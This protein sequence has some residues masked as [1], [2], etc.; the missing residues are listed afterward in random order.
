MPE[1]LRIMRDEINFILKIFMPTVTP[2]NS[3]FAINTR[4]NHS[5]FAENYKGNQ[6]INFN[7]TI[8]F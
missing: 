3:K 4:W 1:N 5:K 6:K 8:T 7:I 2:L